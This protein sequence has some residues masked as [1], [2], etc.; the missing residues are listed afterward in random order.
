MQSQKIKHFDGLIPSNYLRVLLLSF[1]LVIA[2]EIFVASYVF[3]NL[4]DAYSGLE[5]LVRSSPLA[6]ADILAGGVKSSVGESVNT[7]FLLIGAASFSAFA[8]FWSLRKF[9]KLSGLLTT[10]ISDGVCIT[11]KHWKI[12]SFNQRFA[13]IL[14]IDRHDLMG[15]SLISHI[16]ALQKIIDE[17]TPADIGQ[18]E[19]AGTRPNGETF[20]ATVSFFVL[21]YYKGQ[22]SSSFIAVT[23]TTEI[24]RS[25]DNMHHMAYTDDL[26]QLAN[27]PH[28]M[29]K[30]K[31]L[32]E[33]K[34]RLSESFALLYMDLDGFKDINDSMGHVAGDKLLKIMSNRFTCEMRESD[35]VARLGGDEFC[36]I[37]ED[38]YKQSQIQDFASRLLDKISEPVLIKGRK[39]KPRASIGVAIYPN[40]GENREVLLQ[41]ADTAMYEAKHTGKHKVAFYRPELTQ[42]VD[43]SLS[44]EQD[45]RAAVENN[46]FELYYQPQISLNNGGVVGVEAL[47]RWRHPERGLVFPDQFIDV[48]ERIGFIS[49]LGEWTIRKACLQLKEWKKQGVYL[50]MAV[51]ISGSHFQSGGLITATLN[52]IVESGINADQLELE[53]TEGV[54]QVAEKSIRNFHALKEIGVNLAIDDFGTGYSSLS[55]LMTLPV[56][57]L[58]IDRMFL[59]N[60]L[61]DKRQAV[62]ISTIIGMAHALSLHVI[63]EGVE[64]EDQLLLLQGLGCN[65]VQ[66]YYFSKPVSAEKIP[67]IYHQGFGIS[68]ENSNGL[69]RKIGA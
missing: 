19:F 68:R 36:I 2:I 24:R 18:I 21:T 55:S 53:V 43:L 15:E 8:L 14:G 45:L 60:V 46:Q 42:R 5:D 12:R 10:Y 61:Q 35:F 33:Q 57:H 26:T 49:E 47:I 23:D 40:D 41:V 34:E 31:K 44:L 27:R 69:L 13:D 38:V 11:R 17:N 7:L 58:K 22:P 48:A 29:E 62:I 20:I 66:G 4:G 25:Q 9:I 52:A 28:L 65:I 3:M 56:D 37:L 64:T 51:N 54:M 39:L 59:K 6:E 16:P 63:V 67:A 32:I 50:N 1:T 30:L